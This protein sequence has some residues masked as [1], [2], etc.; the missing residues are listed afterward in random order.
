MFRFYADLSRPLSEGAWLTQED[1]HH[2]RDVLRLK[3]GHPVELFMN[4]SRFSAE[5]AESSPAGVRLSVTG[6]L[7]STE[8]ALDICLFQGMP[9]GDKLEWIVQK[10]VEL[11]V[12]KIIPVQMSRCIA[13]PD[14]RS[15]ARKT[16]RLQK[17]A[18]EAGKQSCRCRLPEVSPLLSMTALPDLVRS[19]DAFVVPWEECISPGPKAFSEAHPHPGSLGILIGPE[20]GIA[21]EEIALLQDAGAVPITLGP[22]ILRTETA[23]LAAV[24]AFLSLYEE[25]G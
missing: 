11:G 1:A 22:R 23:G 7:P 2:A 24:S 16:D 25:M 20:G 15:S 10:S 21:P 8:P 14:A 4:E 3:P 5:I 19:F 9:K 17:I 18:R 12:R 13:K 6:V